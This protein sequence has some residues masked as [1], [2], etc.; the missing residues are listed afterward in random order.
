MPF[1][2]DDILVAY[3][4]GLVERRGED[5]DL[6]LQRLAAIAA[7]AT[8]SADGLVDGLV[9]ELVGTTNA[10]DVA[11]LAIRRWPGGIDATAVP[12]PSAASSPGPAP[13][14][15]RRRKCPGPAVDSPLGS[16]R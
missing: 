3:T 1:R 7:R 10:D 14:V 13:A 12:G 16:A 8:S 11:I 4:D 5:I 2:P 9:S 6:G 15:G